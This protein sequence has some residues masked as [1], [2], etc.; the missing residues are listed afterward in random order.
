MQLTSRIFPCCIAAVA[1][2][3]FTIRVTVLLRVHFLS[4]NTEWG[5]GGPRALSDLLDS[6][7]QEANNSMR[8]MQRDF[9]SFLCAPY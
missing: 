4:G 8:D 5:D 6:Q 1:A 9:S 2:E 7:S 3:C